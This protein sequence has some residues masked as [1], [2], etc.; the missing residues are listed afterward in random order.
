MLIKDPLS[1]ERCQYSD[2][3]K[4]DFR[5]THCCGQRLSFLCSTVLAFLDQSAVQAS[6]VTSRHC[7]TLFGDEQTSESHETVWLVNIDY[8]DGCLPCKRENQ[9]TEKKVSISGRMK[10]QQGCRTRASSQESILTSSA[11]PRGASR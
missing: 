6:V 7:L 3:T 4:L 11:S 10:E 2:V 8:K 5:L 9:E 1:A